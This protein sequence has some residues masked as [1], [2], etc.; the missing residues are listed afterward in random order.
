MAQSACVDPA[1]ATNP[2]ARPALPGAQ[3]AQD[4]T[5]LR[6]L[7]APTS[8][9]ERSD[10]TAREA[11]G[12]Q[13]QFL[14]A[15]GSVKMISPSREVLA[16]WMRY[17]MPIDTIRAKGSVSI[18]S[19]QDLIAGPELEYRRDTETGFMK[20][21]NFELGLYKGRGSAEELLFTG[22]DQYRVL[23]GTYSTCVDKSPAWR[24]AVGTLDIN[25]AT[26]VGVAKDAKVYL[27]SLPI[28]WLP[29]FSFPLKNERK[30][31]FLSPTYG[32]S[33]SRGFDFQI[34]YYLNLAPNYDATLTPRL[35]TKRGGMLNGQFR[36]I[37]NTSLGMSSGEW[38]AEI[39]PKDNQTGTTRRAE[40]LRHMQLFTPN[41]SLSLNF[42]RV[43]DARYFID[44][45][46]YVAITS[47]TTLPR[48]ATLTYR[49]FDW[50]F[51]AKAQRFQ[52]LQ[53]PAALVLPP[54]DR[55]PQLTAES[56]LY[57]F[58]P[59]KR[60]EAKIA[61]DVTRFEY[62]NPS[63]PSGYRSYALGSL[64]YRYETP[65]GFITPKV[66][67][68][69]SNYRLTGV[70][71][72]YENSNRVLPI[73]SVDGG[74]FFDRSTKIFGQAFQQTL[75]PRAMFT[76]IPYRDQSKTPF[77]DTALADFNHLQLFSENR[78]VGQD[79]IGDAAQLSV[80]VTSRLFDPVSQKERLRVTLGER[81]YF[82]EQ[83][84]TL[85]ET[86]R[87][88]NASDILLSAQGRVTDA[89]YF[90]TN[91]QYNASEGRSER[92]SAGLRYTPDRARTLNLNYRSIREL[93]TQSGSVRVR[94][95]DASLQWPIYRNLY[96]IGRVN[97][98][99]ADRRL[100]E[101]VIGLEY[102]GCCYVVRAVA[103]RIA[104]ST[105]TATTAYFLQLELIG[106]ARVGANPLDILKRNIPG[107]SLLYDNPTR[108]R[109]D[110]PDSPT[111]TPWTPN[112]P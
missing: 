26:G 80:G 91:A 2:L 90:E 14:E 104:T 42:N 111:F 56:P 105:T 13:D 53:D 33:A 88:R 28:L 97:F 9:K 16:D 8:G 69:A 58:G 59:S 67:L 32:S 101:G 10:V 96:G 51:S 81:F 65:G 50:V 36:Y 27:G 74:L 48:D 76:Y 64:A 83:K 38:L 5:P 20:S 45:A 108:R 25:D 66:S 39:L 41:L 102:D 109:V 86:P 40:N 78:Y 19:W 21:P 30:S 79:R 98:S 1:A 6:R 112:T 49:K 63:F 77:F 3:S 93:A 12:V 24:L 95:V 92:F 70:F 103:Q 75:E 11:F 7:R 89:L 106:L 85:G 22:P 100:T 110:N 17:E 73:T 61:A 4:S 72:D 68:H 94:Q 71:D 82:N 34:P 23:R 99:L 31:G 47:I 44:L 57:R 46:D 37:E 29:Q 62:P 52:T 18:R 60:F 43:S 55:L 107:Y 84:V 35:M 87:D 54:Y 15:V